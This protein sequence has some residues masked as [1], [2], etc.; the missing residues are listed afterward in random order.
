MNEDKRFEITHSEEYKPYIEALCCLAS[1]YVPRIRIQFAEKAVDKFQD[2]TIRKLV[3]AY[4]E[5][6][7]K[8]DDDRLQDFMWKAAHPEM[9]AHNLED[10]CLNK[11]RSYHDAIKFLFEIN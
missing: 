10:S 8:L 11:A 3:L 1:D 4:G 2:E 7:K 6:A 9:M 5:Q